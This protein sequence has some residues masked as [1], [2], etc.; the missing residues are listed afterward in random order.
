MQMATLKDVAERAGVTVTTVSRMLNGRVKV[1]TATQERIQNA[2]REIGYYPNEMAR[3]LSR[4]N[5]SFI[6]LIV[7]SAKNY[8]FAEL[9]H[10]VE[11]AA[12]ANHCR[13]VLCVSNQKGEVAQEYFEML[14][15]NKVMGVIMGNYESLNQAKR[16]AAPLVV[17]EQP[18]DPAI[19]CAKTDDF[20][21]GRL[22][23]EH[24][25][26]KGCRHILYLSGDIKIKRNSV[27]QQRF[28][29][30]CEACREKGVDMPIAIETGW[31]EFRSMNYEKTVS[32]IFQKYPDTDG[33]FASNDLIAASAVSFCRKQGID[34]PG[35]IK[36]VG[37]DDTSFASLCAMP[38]TT[39]HQPIEELARYAVECVI[40]RANDETVPSTTVFPV[41]LVE[42]ETTSC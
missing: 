13:L 39:I 36:I 14:M 32:R 31:D 6:G 35:K 28:N 4:K 38:L 29:G 9:I 34:V 37:Y 20:Q 10:Y 18:D 16:S 7:P 30:L 11:A 2:M 3:S 12:E 41:R 1:S 15:S 24:L 42:R 22:A 8:F 23:G 19:P 5:S 17:F 40:R 27:S 21:G 25:V 33:V 26:S